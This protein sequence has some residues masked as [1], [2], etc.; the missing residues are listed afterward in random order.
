MCGRIAW[1]FETCGHKSATWIKRCHR[2]GICPSAYDTPVDYRA[3]KVA[4]CSENCCDNDVNP[5]I[6][7]VAVK[8]QLWGR[9]V[10]Q[11]RPILIQQAARDI[12]DSEQRLEAERQRHV[13]C[14]GTWRNMRAE[15]R[16]DEMR[17]EA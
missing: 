8:K 6:A 10:A 16:S 4:C 1:F 13:A 17:E 7:D 15:R 14:S 3:E 9:A 11:G 5:C 2:A 12:E